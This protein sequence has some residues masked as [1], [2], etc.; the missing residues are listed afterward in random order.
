MM[1]SPPTTASPVRLIF[2]GSFLD[3][4]ALILEKLLTDERLQIVTVVTTPPMPMGRKQV[5]TKTP[6]HISAEK[7]G[8]T[9]FAPEKLTTESLHELLSLAGN[10]K[11]TFFVTAGYGK[12]LPTEW[13]TAPLAG[14]LNLHFSLL[15]AY[16]GANPAEW[17]LLNDEKTTGLTLIE[18]SPEFD[19]GRMIAQTP[20][21]ITTTDTR[22]TVYEKLY[23]LGSQVLPNWLVTYA[24]WLAD[25]TTVPPTDTTHW[26]L[27]PVPQPA[28]T[29]PYAKRFTR[30]DGFI[31]W[32]AVEATQQGDT[33]TA[34]ELG[35]L[36][37]HIATISTLALD[38]AWIE[39]ATR[40]LAGFPNLW[41][42]V[43]TIRGDKRMKILSA[44][45]EGNRLRLEAVQVE[46][47]QAT[48]WNAIKGTL[49]AK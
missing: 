16:R 43:P 44:T 38:A 11:P 31:A 23:T 13:L 46:G 33:F 18:M 42:T 32:S 34:E 14:S 15:P 3:Y 24:T 29:T 28:A 21:A 41:T 6:V 37:K 47:M 1:S 5:L 30:D 25:D 2:F 9:V 12:L 19:T 49:L 8:V 4:S 35:P 7:H 22:E 36:L 39:R 27:P 45:V 26:W 48:A 40:A 10:E 17:A 20:M